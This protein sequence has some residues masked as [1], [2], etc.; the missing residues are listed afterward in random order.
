M[1]LQQLQYFVTVCK[2]QN[3]T[4]AARELAVSQP[5]IS[6]A[7]RELEAEC[8]FALFEHKP[9]SI[10]LTDQG[11]GFLREAEQLLH[12][13]RKLQ[14]NAALIAKEKTILRIGVAPMGAGIVFPRLRKG[15]HAACPD[16]TFE[17]TEGPTEELYQ[18]IDTGEL[19]FALCVSIAPPG[20]E[21]RCVTVGYSRL[22]FCV[23]RKAPLA[24][25]EVSSL[26]QIGQTPLV[27]L[28][29]HYSQ[30]KY[31]KRLFANEGCTPNVIQYTSQVFTILQHIRE[32]AAAGFLSEDIAR[33]DSG[34]VGFALRE[35]QEASITM[36]WKKEANAFPAAD[37]FV[38][39]LRREKKRW[40]Q[41]APSERNDME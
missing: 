20:E 21:Y 17:V 34:L 11:G 9:N 30:T 1:T 23:N 6:T 2:Y 5:G 26:R 40:S 28:A 41:A 39:Y 16:I 37:Q 25:M 15:F 13:Y 38:Q 22:L 29:D 18:K 31:L 12:A 8:G 14:K 24:S 3:L 4:K 36:I 10:A 35:V 32:N 33:Q 27:M 19:D 7:I